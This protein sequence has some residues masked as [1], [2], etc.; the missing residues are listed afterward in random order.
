VGA[1]FS[2]PVQTGPGDHPASC[3][4]GTGSLPGVKRPRRGVDHPPHLAPWLKK[5]L[6][7]TLTA[8]LDLRGLF[9]DKHYRLLLKTVKCRFRCPCCLGR[10]AAAVSNPAEGVDICLLCCEGSG[11]CDELI[12]R[13]EESHRLPVSCLYYRN[14]HNEATWVRECCRVAENKTSAPYHALHYITFCKFVLILHS[15]K[16]PSRY[17][18]GVA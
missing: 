15:L 14:I 10:F 5:E 8:P 18:P 12:T 9:W 3:T 6:S 1:R 11:L 7:Y 4:M 16:Q 17:R 13:P 2:A